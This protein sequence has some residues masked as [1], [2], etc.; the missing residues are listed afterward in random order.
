MCSIFVLKEHVILGMFCVCICSR[1]VMSSCKDGRWN[2]SSSILNYTHGYMM[3]VDTD[4]CPQGTETHM[5]ECICTYLVYLTDI[6]IRHTFGV[7]IEMP[8]SLDGFPPE[9]VQDGS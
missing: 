6:L 3:T 5:L 2:I 9:T 4:L 8:V 7:R 1:Q